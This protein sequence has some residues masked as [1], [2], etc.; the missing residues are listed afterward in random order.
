MSH[1]TRVARTDTDTDTDTAAAADFV[2]RFG[3]AWAGRDPEA[4]GALFHADAEIDYPT[5]DGMIDRAG[6]V[7]FWQAVLPLVPTMQ[8]GVVR[9]AHAGDDVFIEWES[10]VDGQAVQRGVDRFTLRDGRAVSEGNY[11]D[12]HAV[13]PVLEGAR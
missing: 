6:V 11:W 12:T 1:D 13:R 10:T 7:A 3:L 4:L 9:W 5:E 2:E 8:V